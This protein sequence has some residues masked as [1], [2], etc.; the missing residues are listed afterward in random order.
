MSRSLL[1]AG[2]VSKAAWIASLA[3]DQVDSAVLGGG[4]VLG[5]FAVV[6]AIYHVVY[7]LLDRMMQLPEV[8]ELEPVRLRIRE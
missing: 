1:V 5:V 7:K 3:I 4:L 2:L 6:P 8:F